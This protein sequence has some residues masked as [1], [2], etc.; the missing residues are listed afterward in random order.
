M[1]ASFGPEK[2][3][4]NGPHG[5]IVAGP[6]ATLGGYVDSLP[7][8]H[9]KIMAYSFLRHKVCHHHKLWIK[10]NCKGAKVESVRGWYGRV[11]PTLKFSDSWWN[12]V[13][14]LIDMDFNKGLT[15]PGVIVR[16]S[17]PFSPSMFKEDG[18]SSQINDSHR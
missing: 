6:I 5:E 1:E 2:Y 17:M 11:P 9:G 10:T 13:A 8:I 3:F 14:V 16:D 7:S 15:W 12:L 18:N 4:T